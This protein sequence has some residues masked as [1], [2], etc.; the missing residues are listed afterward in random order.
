VIVYRSSPSQK[1]ETVKFIRKH[2]G[3]GLFNSLV[4]MAIGDGAN[5][6]NMIQTAHVG[7]GI[8]GKEGNQASSFADY[9]LPKF[10]DLRQ[11]LLWHGRCFG[12]RALNFTCW[13]IFKDMIASI[14][15]I[16]LN[17]FGGYSGILYENW[18]VNLFMEI[19]ILVVAT[20]IWFEVTAAPKF[21]D[22]AF[23]SSYLALLYKH[24][25]QVE[26]KPMLK[27]FAVWNVYAWYTG[28]VFFYFASE[29]LNGIHVHSDKAGRND[30]M[31]ISGL[32][33]YLML[34]TV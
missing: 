14:P 11:L 17:V 5:D 20:Y 25:K 34:G 10:Q 7:I 3:A 32:C 22:P 1:A 13:M 33:Q 26:T 2:A 21:K 23:P 6:V 24:N 19:T 18:Y 16:F 8:Q 9:A 30:G 31:D 29:S 28:I 12:T 27:K 4:T 15:L